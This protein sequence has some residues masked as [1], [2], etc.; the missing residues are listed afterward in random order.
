MKKFAILL[1]FATF[2]W[3]HS[4]SL[5]V[6]SEGDEIRVSGYFYGGARCKN[7]EILLK[8][9]EK[10]VQKFS[11]DKNGELRFKASAPATQIC[12]LGGAGHQKC[13]DFAVN[14]DG[15]KI[16]KTSENFTPNLPKNETNTTKPTSEMLKFVLS[17]AGIFAFFAIL[18]FLKRQR[19]RSKSPCLTQA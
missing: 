12:I 14:F 1:F 13:K 3:S 17:F 5:F 11:T 10:I 9:G 19:E 16:E 18:F 7:C 6:N 2:L 8:N 4:M 15:T